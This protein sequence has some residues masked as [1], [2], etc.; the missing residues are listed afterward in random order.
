MVNKNLEDEIAD[1]ADECAI[2]QY[3]IGIQVTSLE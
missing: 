2:R 3:E 1:L